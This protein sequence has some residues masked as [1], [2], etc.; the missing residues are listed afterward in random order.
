MIVPICQGHI[1]LIPFLRVFPQSIGIYTVF[2][3]NLIFGADFFSNPNYILLHFINTKPTIMKLD[4]PNSYWI[5]ILLLALFLGAC[6]Q[7][8]PE[9]PGPVMPDTEPVSCSP[10]DTLIPISEVVTWTN[11]WSQFKD[12]DNNNSATGSF[13]D[14][15][16]IDMA[17]I[18]SLILPEGN[19]SEGFRIY[20][21]L[22]D[23]SKRNSAVMLV[24]RTDDNCADYTSGVDCQT[25]L[26]VLPAGNTSSTGNCAEPHYVTLDDAKTYTTNWRNFYGI[27]DT[28]SDYATSGYN[29]V[30]Y[31][32]YTFDTEKFKNEVLDACSTCT[33]LDV[34]PGIDEDGT[35][36]TY[37]MVLFSCGGEG[38]S[39]CGIINTNGPDRY[40]DISAPCPQNCGSNNVLQSSSN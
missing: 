23:A 37:K 1:S 39:E 11:A 28:N 13:P 21:G 30:I 8:S 18:E 25:L 29:K 17:A 5:P 9:D 12:T 24:A 22:T 20:F 38:N 19:E 2:P 26:V 16:V 4:L 32:A 3:F 7:S 34:Y 33:S 27:S 35:K 14:R 15:F 36:L 31:L 6:G 10:A 40:L